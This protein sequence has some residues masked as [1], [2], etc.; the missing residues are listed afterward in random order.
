MAP[1]VSLRKFDCLKENLLLTRRCTRGAAGGD[2]HLL[3]QKIL[4][5]VKV[6]LLCWQGGAG[7]A[8]GSSALEAEDVEVDSSP[9]SC[10]GAC[11][12][13]SSSCGGG[14]CSSMLVLSAALGSAP[15]CRRPSPQPLNFPRATFHPHKHR[16]CF[17]CR[18]PRVSSQQQE[19]KIDTS[20]CD[21]RREVEEQEAEEVGAASL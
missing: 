1:R 3:L 14:G 8:R 13:S 18:P 4:R 9:P 19:A 12:C 21:R 20:L 7:V 11:C 10:S 15:S 5:P 6:L 16:K 2:T 17:S